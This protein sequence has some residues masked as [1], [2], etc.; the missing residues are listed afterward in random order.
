[1]QPTS[2]YL[3][4]THTHTSALPQ[5]SNTGWGMT[6][7]K[8]KEEKE[9]ETAV[10]GKVNIKCPRYYRRTIPPG[11]KISVSTWLNLSNLGRGHSILSFKKRQSRYSACHT[12]PHHLCKK[13]KR[14]PHMT[15]IIAQE[16]QRPVVPIAGW[17]ATLANQWGPG[18]MER[19]CFKN[20]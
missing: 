6:N 1:M 17:P 18:S 4:R 7:Q 11:A 5:M 10:S 9:G 12:G 19:L 20:K 3:C 15:M 16:D 13:A 14:W 2:S 8:I